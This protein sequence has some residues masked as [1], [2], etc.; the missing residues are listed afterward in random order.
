MLLCVRELLDMDDSEIN[1]PSVSI[2]VSR[3]VNLLPF[4]SGT[5]GVPKGVMLSHR[6]ILANTLQV[7]AIEK[8]E[9]S[10]LMLLPMFH[11][12]P[13][14]LMNLSLYQGVAQVVLPKFEPET[15]LNALQTYKVS[16]R[17]FTIASMSLTIACLS[18]FLKPI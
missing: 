6:N 18:R 1:V 2:D 16:A 5:T 17:F 9:N 4:S 14:L 10:T 3:D 11:I 13:F 12:Y 7:D 8:F 15:L